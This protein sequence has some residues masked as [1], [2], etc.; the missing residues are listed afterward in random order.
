MI[1][2]WVGVWFI[3]LGLIETLISRIS[4]KSLCAICTTEQL[5][6]CFFLILFVGI[7]YMVCG[8]AILS[9]QQ[10]NFPKVKLKKG[11]RKN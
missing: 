9:M 4:C 8:L 3:I 2:K 5:N 10:N 6:P 7:I 1:L 11:K